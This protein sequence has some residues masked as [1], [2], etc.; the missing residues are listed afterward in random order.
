MR[1]LGLGEQNCPDGTFAAEYVMGKWQKW[2]V[3]CLANLSMEDMEE[4]LYL[5]GTL[6]TSLLI[7]LGIALVHR[8][9][10]K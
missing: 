10:K 5:F 4:D 6:I 8:E 9:K 3:V 7:G 1:S 2:H